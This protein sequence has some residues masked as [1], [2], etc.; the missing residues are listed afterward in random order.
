MTSAFQST[1]TFLEAGT[2]ESTIEGASGTISVAFSAPAAAP[3]SQGDLDLVLSFPEGLDPRRS[4][5]IVELNGQTIA[6]VMVDGEEN[7]RGSYRVDLP[8]DVL[9][10]G[11]NTL[12]LRANLYDTQSLVLAP[13][14][15]TAPERLWMTIHDNSAIRLPQTAGAATGSDLGALPFPFAGLTGIRDTVVVVNALDTDALRAGMF[16]IVAL[17]R[18]FGAQNQFT[19][20]GA[21]EATPESLGDNHVIA[22]AAPPTSPLGLELERILPLVLREGGSRALVEEEGTLTEILDSSRIGAIQEVEVPW[23]RGRALLSVSGTDSVALGWAADALI[24]RSLDGN[25]ALLQ[26]A[27]QINT[28]Q[29]QRLAIGAPEDLEDRFTEQDARLRIILS[30]ALIVAGATAV[31]LIYG[32]RGRIRPRFGLPGRRR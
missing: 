1:F 25:V 26:S 13:C 17:G 3:G 9:R 21:L 14:E 29:L 15:S 27:R 28:F 32:L 4:N 5:I 7:R 11:P 16:T 31:I 8:W 22:V 6:T 2:S 19:V 30:V 12:T 20:Q 24:E 23:A 18:A 10:I